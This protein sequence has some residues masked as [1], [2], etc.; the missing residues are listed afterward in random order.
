MP[1]KGIPHFTMDIFDG[2]PGL[3]L[4]GGLDSVQGQP[5]GAAHD[6]VLKTGELFRDPPSTVFPSGVPPCQ[7]PLGA[8]LSVALIQVTPCHTSR[9]QDAF[10]CVPGSLTALPTADRGIPRSPGWRESRHYATVTHLA[11]ARSHPD[12][13]QG[14]P[15]GE[16]SQTQSP[17]HS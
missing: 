15:P 17:H 8:F 9:P 7:P 1:I 14:L 4:Q 12:G 10:G 5:N 11:Q 3:Q 6:A 16:L 13:P 2:M